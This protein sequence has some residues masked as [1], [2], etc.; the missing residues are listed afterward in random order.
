MEREERLR[1]G[2]QEALNQ[3][4]QHP[5]AI[6]TRNN[7]FLL[8]QSGLLAYTLNL[9]AEPDR[10]NRLIACAAGLF[11]AVVWLWV[12]WAG[13]RLQRSWRAV[14]I[15][16]ENEIFRQDVAGQG[17]AGPFARARV[18]EGESVFV[19]VTLVLMILSAG[20]IFLWVWLLLRELYP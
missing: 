8:I 13:R 11:L 15:E 12:N 20:F 5:P 1:L 9:S 19:S 14:V 6:W 4:R 10:T 7:F 3:L 2:Y 16:F 17:V 18:R